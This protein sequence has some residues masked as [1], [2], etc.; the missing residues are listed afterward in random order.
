MWSKRSERM[1]VWHCVWDPRC[2][3]NRDFWDKNEILASFFALRLRLCTRQ[4]SNDPLLFTD[5]KM[6][7]CMLFHV[8]K[9]DL[10]Y[11]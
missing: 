3:K 4:T 8:V 9:S 5:G 1:G 7:F 2:A 11:L 10:A 6:C